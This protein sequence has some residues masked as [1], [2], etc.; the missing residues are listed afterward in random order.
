MIEKTVR[1]GIGVFVFKEGKF[2]MLQR[3]GDHG[4]GSWSVPGGHQEFG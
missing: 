1:V 3:H 2:L 4:F